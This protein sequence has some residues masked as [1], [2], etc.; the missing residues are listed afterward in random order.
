MTVRHLCKWISRA[1]Y[2][3]CPRGPFVVKDAACRLR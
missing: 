1:M 2:H 3:A